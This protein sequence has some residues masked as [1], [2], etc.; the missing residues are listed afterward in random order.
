VLFHVNDV[1]ESVNTFISTIP[2]LIWLYYS[3][4]FECTMTRFVERSPLAVRLVFMCELRI[5]K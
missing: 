3:I 2:R 4:C 5:Y 1:A